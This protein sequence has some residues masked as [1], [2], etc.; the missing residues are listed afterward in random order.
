MAFLD[1]IS[2]YGQYSIQ[3]RIL[4]NVVQFFDYGLLE[5]G[6]FYNITKGTTDKFNNDLSKLRTTDNKIFN[7]FKGG[8]IWESGINMKDSSINPPINISGIYVDI[9]F[10]FF[11]S[12]SIGNGYHINYLDGQIIFNT[13]IQK[14]S[15]VQLDYSTKFIHVALAD[16]N[17]YRDAVSYYQNKNLLFINGSGLDGFN[18]K[19]SLPAVFIGVSKMTTT[20]IGLGSRDRYANA[21][22]NIDIFC[23][24]PSDKKKISDIFYAAT[25]KS[26]KPYDVNRAILP[27][28][29]SGT[30]QN[31]AYTFPDLVKNYPHN[32][33][34]ARFSDDFILSNDNSMNLPIQH[35]NV[36]MI[37]EF[38]VT[39]N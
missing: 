28:S 35:S 10:F 15:V 7:G 33:P 26:F 8:W 39:I 36:R 20:P 2:F 19:F 4:H 32:Y 34:F 3:D 18:N 29:A 13:A 21:T 23:E 22:L 24:N 37:I 12:T 6:A 38:P 14:N 1:S 16:T 11:C 17:R 9:I 30:L 27:I 25:E 31:P 5:L